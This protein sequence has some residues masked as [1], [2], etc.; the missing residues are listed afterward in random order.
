[1]YEYDNKSKMKFGLRS[2]LRWMRS[3]IEEE[4]IDEILIFM[5]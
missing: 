5:E 1:M 3:I 2:F 4:I